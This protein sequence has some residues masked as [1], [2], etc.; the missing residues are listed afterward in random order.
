M[1]AKLKAG[2]SVS[3]LS[4]EYLSQTCANL[5]NHIEQVTAIGATIS[6]Q[7]KDMIFQAAQTGPVSGLQ[8]QILEAFTTF[9]CTTQKS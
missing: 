3:V 6:Y 5:K 4:F 2:D 7:A 1:I 9:E 8:F